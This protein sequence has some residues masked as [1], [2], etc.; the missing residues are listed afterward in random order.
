VAGAELFR[1]KKRLIRNDGAIQHER[2][3]YYQIFVMS[4]YATLW[5]LKF[6]REGD[7]FLDCD[8]IKVTAQG[9]PPHIGSPTEGLGYE[10]GDPYAAFLPPPVATDENG[11]DP[12]LRA[13]V[14]VTEQTVKGTNRSPQ[15][16]ADP[17][18][19]ISGEE[20]ARITFADL[21]KRLCEALRVKASPSRR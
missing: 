7:D 14:F 15:E 21:H 2:S 11:D 16:Y 17:L 10:D 19:V 6:P 12:F 20:Y 8:W 4:I 9:V 3:T 1:I 13:I 18:L 5:T